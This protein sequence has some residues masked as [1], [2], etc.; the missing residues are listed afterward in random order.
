MAIQEKTL[1][2][3]TILSA[4]NSTVYTVPASTTTIVKTIWICNTTTS[5]VTVEMWVVPNG[6]SAGDAYKLMDGV[7]IPASDFIQ[8]STYLPMETAGDTIQLKG[9][10]NVALTANIF[11]AEIT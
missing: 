5:D 4:S 2:Q 1:G 3:S 11:G 10:T 8:V 7:T 6:Q 9:S